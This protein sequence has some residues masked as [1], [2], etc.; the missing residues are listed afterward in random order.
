MRKGVLT[1][2]ALLLIAALTTEMATA[3]RHI[4]KAAR[5]SATVPQQLRKPHGFSAPAASDAKSC[6]VV[7]C[8]S[9]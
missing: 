2:L 6:D 5:G 8:Y 9:D 7:W 3:A 4:R 1:V